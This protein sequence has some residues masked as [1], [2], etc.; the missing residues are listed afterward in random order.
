MISPKGN[1]GYPYK[2]CNIEVWATCH[3]VF[4]R[5]LHNIINQSEKCHVSYD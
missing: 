3:F 1:L 5:K 2:N 4:V